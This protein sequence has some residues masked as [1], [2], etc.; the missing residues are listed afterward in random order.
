MRETKDSSENSSFMPNDNFDT[1]FK[2]VVLRL[3][4]DEPFIVFIASLL[5]KHDYFV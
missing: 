1:I 4:V 2:M 5:E 3:G